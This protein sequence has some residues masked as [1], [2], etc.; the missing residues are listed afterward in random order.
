M[1]KY[2]DNKDTRF[3][4]IIMFFI[5]I[6][7]IPIIYVLKILFYFGSIILNLFLLMDKK[8]NKSK[9]LKKDRR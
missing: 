6:V 9:D 7:F 3:D 8:I 2:S 5:K 4:K 1:I